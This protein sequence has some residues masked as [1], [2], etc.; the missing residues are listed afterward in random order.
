MNMVVSMG[1]SGIV[2]AAAF[3]IGAESI[4]DWLWFPAAVAGLVTTAVVNALTACVACV[5]Y[6]DLR[7]RR[8]GWD[9]RREITAAFGAGASAGAG[10]GGEP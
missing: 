3:L 2:Y 6:L 1:T 5:L 10:A 4:V 8:D 9:L 7:S